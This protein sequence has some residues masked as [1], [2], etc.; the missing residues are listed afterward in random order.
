MS[1]KGDFMLGDKVIFDGEGTKPR[2]KNRLYGLVVKVGPSRLT[3]ETADGERHVRE[4]AKVARYLSAPKNWNDLY[5]GIMRLS[6]VRE[7]SAL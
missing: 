2:L 1:S 4:R 7:S 6:P 3:I 5:Q